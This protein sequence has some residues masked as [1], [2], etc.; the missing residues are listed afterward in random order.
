MSSKDIKKKLVQILGIIIYLLAFVALGYFIAFLSNSKTELV[1]RRDGGFI[2]LVSVAL[3][4]YLHIII[5][6]GGHFLFG[7]LTGYRLTSFRIGSITIMKEEDKIKLKRFSIAGTGGQC[8]MEPPEYKEDK[9]PFILYNLGGGLLN[10][11]FSIIAIIIYL[12]FSNMP[13]LLEILLSF[14]GI[15]IILGLMN[16]IPLKIA[17]AA[18]DGYNIIF[19]KKNKDARYAF[20]RQLKINA[21]LA[22]GARI[23]DMPKEWFELSEG[24]DINNPIIAS[25]ACMMGS[26]YQDNK[27]FQRSKEEFDYVLENSNNLLGIYKNE[28][29]CE[30]LFYEIIGDRNI[31]KINKLFTK[32]LKKYIKASKHSLSKKRL[33]Y[34]Y[35]LLINKDENTAKK[36][37]DEFEKIAKTYPYKGEVEGERELISFVKQ[38]NEEIFNKS[39]DSISI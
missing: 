14:S 7:K 34:A 18:N 35:E 2:F 39:N 26:Y 25:V 11:I 3:S 24:A 29:E 22:R 20:Y 19:L 4:F 6:E 37:L 15:G 23:K 33:L 13:Y 36:Y 9:F 17:G 1:D 12:I 5:H 16:I 38:N 8:L 10:I 27:D 21:L 31:D 30:L 32:E 28:I